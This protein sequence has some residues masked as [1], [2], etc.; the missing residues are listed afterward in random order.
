MT[1]VRYPESCLR[2]QHRWSYVLLGTGGVV[3]R[4]ADCRA[5][6]RYWRSAGYC[7]RQGFV[8]VTQLEKRETPDG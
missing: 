1:E 8:P 4:C 7:L 2:G 6:G 5:Y 3:Q